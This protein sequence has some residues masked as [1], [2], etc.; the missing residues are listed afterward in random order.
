MEGETRPM[1]SEYR[2]GQVETPLGYVKLALRACLMSRSFLLLF[3]I[4]QCF[5]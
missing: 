2:F 4:C 3:L 1:L 5:L